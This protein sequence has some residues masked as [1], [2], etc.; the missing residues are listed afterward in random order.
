M[1]AIINGKLVTPNGIIENKVLIFNETIQRI[2]DEVPTD[3]SVIDAK[4]MYIAPGLI[5]VHV[6][7]S[8]GADTMDQTVE[9]IELISAG[10]VKNGVTSF[11]PTTMTMSP[12]HIYGALDKVRECMNQPLNGAKVL[13]A[14]MEGPF[15]NAIYKGAQP[16]QFIIK[17]SYEFIQDYTDVIKLVSYAPEMDE[18][19][20]FTKEVKEKTDITLSM[21]HT[22]AT[23][24]QAKEA[25]ACGC[26][27]VT[28][29]FNA[30]TPLN[31]REPGVVGAALTSDVFTELIADTIH[32]NKQ[33]FQFVLDNKGKQK[34]VLITDS[35]RAG[36]MKDGQY[37]LGGQAVFVKDGAAR[38]ESGNLAGSVLTLNKAIYNFCQNT[39][40]TLDEVIHMASLNPATSIGVADRKGSLE[41]GKD[42]DIAIFDEEMNCYLSI[43]E[44][45]EVYNQI[46]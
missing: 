37:D 6:H 3:C 23:Y 19:Y 42:A 7:G 34:M 29:L 12:A 36:C 25:F 27:H 33:L 44:G 21:G 46:H 11:L 13:G 40:A 1:K 17:P 28:H 20:S 5:D 39:N 31:H 26:S 15:I 2:Q 24:N 8:C 38:L 10:V 18:N 32:V 35:M 16:E 43:V 4:G 22:N 41:I 45:R 30:M 9:A 14:H